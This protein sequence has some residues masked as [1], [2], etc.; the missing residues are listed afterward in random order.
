MVG[1]GSIT[2]L[3]LVC[4]PH[5]SVRSMK[6]M[7]KEE[8]LTEGNKYYISKVEFPLVSR[9]MDYLVSFLKWRDSFMHGI[10]LIFW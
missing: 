8:F 7:R 2:P 10:I 1:S 5:G 6:H 3:S 4:N 9:N